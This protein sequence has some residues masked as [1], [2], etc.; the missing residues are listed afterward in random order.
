MYVFLQV[1]KYDEFCQLDIQCQYRDKNSKCNRDFSL[2]ECQNRY[3][4][5]SY[6]DGQQWCI[7]K[8]DLYLQPTKWILIVLYRIHKCIQRASLTISYLW[9]HICCIVIDKVR[10]YIQLLIVPNKSQ[11]LDTSVGSHLDPTMIGIMCGLI[12]MF[13]VICVVLQ[14][15]AKYVFT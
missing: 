7:G 13:I 14:L 8:S 15:F 4:A 2:C 11:V 3:V 5:K 12:L 6:S 1:S 10:F 9:I